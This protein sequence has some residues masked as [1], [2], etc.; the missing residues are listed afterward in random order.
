MKLFY[1]VSDVKIFFSMAV[2]EPRMVVCN[3]VALRT[4]LMKTEESVV[5]WRRLEAV[6]Q[7]QRDHVE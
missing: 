1:C 7:T 3:P 2:D 5:R 6:V 4:I